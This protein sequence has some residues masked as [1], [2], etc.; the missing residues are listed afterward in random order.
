MGHDYSLSPGSATSRAWS[1]LPRGCCVCLLGYGSKPV[2]RRP[3]CNSSLSRLSDL[4][5]G[6]L[7]HWVQRLSIPLPGLKVL[8]VP[9]L[10]SGWLIP[11]LPLVGK[12]E[13]AAWLRK[14]V[15]SCKLLLGGL[16]DF[17]YTGLAHPPQ[18]SLSTGGGS[19]VCVKPR[20]SCP[21][22]GVFSVI[23]KQGNRDGEA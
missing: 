16:L 4:C 14:A 22:S 21:F 18:G 1:F 17:A 13:R 20:A 6:I 10:L 11:T 9:G 8:S 7:V 3:L 5:L 12:P 15:V 23:Q 2:G 19:G